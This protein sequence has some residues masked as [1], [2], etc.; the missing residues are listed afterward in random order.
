MQILLDPAHPAKEV[1]FKIGHSCVTI[2]RKRV[3]SGLV[4]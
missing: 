3:L 2:T 4:N 1:A